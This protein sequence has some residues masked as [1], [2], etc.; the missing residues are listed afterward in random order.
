MS[1][2]IDD[3]IQGLNWR[4]VNPLLICQV[5]THLSEVVVISDSLALNS[6]FLKAGDNSLPPPIDLQEMGHCK[7]RPR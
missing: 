5:P 3:E 2:Q 6:R 1:L 7:D 4:A